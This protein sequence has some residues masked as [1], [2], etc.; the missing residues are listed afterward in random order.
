M[1]T[2]KPVTGQHQGHDFA[3]AIAVA[4][5]PPGTGQNLRQ[6][7]QFQIDA[8]RQ[9]LPITPPLLVASGVLGGTAKRVVDQF[10]H[11]HA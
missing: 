11:S 6:R 3:L 7:L 8:R 1:V 10:I 9:S 4:V 2:P 5:D